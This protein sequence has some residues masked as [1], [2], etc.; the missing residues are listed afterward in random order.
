LVRRGV[1]LRQ[2]KHHTFPNSLQNWPN[3]GGV[4]PF[5]LHFSLLSLSKA[6][7]KALS[8]HWTFHT[9]KVDAPHIGGRNQLP[10]FGTHLIQ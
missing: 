8:A 7:R 5:C 2:S 6:G 10:T 1:Q 9:I 3:L 4:G